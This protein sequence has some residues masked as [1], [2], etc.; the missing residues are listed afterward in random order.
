MVVDGVD[1]GMSSSSSSSFLLHPSSLISPLSLSPSLNFFLPFDRS[2]VSS[3]KSSSLRSRL[4]S[5][6]HTSLKLDISRPRCVRSTQGHRR[7][8]E[9]PLLLRFRV[10]NGRFFLQISFNNAGKDKECHGTPPIS[11]A[12]L[13]LSLSR[14]LVLNFFFQSRR[15][16]EDKASSTSSPS[17]L[18]SS[19]P[20]PLLSTTTMRPVDE[21]LYWDVA[22]K[23]G[24]LSF[25]DRQRSP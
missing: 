18:S 9:V 23:D 2:S 17:G 4:L 19:L 1:D 15:F 16:F 6:L 5:R 8:V 20:L 13:S 11:L 21:E 22:A 25:L 24:L 10:K 14:L 7:I 3:R 12:H